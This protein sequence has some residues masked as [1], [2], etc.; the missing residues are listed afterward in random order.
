MPPLHGYRQL[1]IFFITSAIILYKEKTKEN[2][3]LPIW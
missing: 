3:V 2:N 1:R